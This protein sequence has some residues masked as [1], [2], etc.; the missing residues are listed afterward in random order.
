[1]IHKGGGAQMSFA[2]EN[3]AYMKKIA[4]NIAKFTKWSTGFLGLFLLLLNSATFAQSGA[5]SEDHQQLIDEINSRRYSPV[6]E[7][8]RSYRAGLKIVLMAKYRY[9]GAFEVEEEWPV[10]AMYFTLNYN[11]SEGVNVEFQRSDAYQITNGMGENKIDLKRKKASGRFSGVSVE[12][13]ISQYRNSLEKR[14]PLYFRRFILPVPFNPSERKNAYT[15]MKNNQLVLV[16]DLGYPAK[17]FYYFDKLDKRLQF[18]V[19]QGL[20]G[21]PYPYNV[22]LPV[23]KYN[24]KVLHR[25]YERDQK[26]VRGMETNVNH[27]F[28]SAEK[29]KGKGYEGGMGFIFPQEQEGNNLS[30]LNIWPKR[31]YFFD[32]AD[33]P[34]NI[35]SEENQSLPLLRSMRVVTKEKVVDRRKLYHYNVGDQAAEDGG[36]SMSTKLEVYNTMTEHFFVEQVRYNGKILR[37]TEEG[38]FIQSK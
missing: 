17:I 30:R 9:Q 28:F 29:E 4:M 20:K 38:K 35:E 37:E 5:V 19:F 11:Q 36:A 13:F 26:Y 7:G 24:L 12:R 1:M 27:Y 25:T 32:Y 18:M 33:V 23:P 22:R 34:L 31:E 14:I 21:P 8:I 6:R 10:I 15:Y 16:E 2:K 3:R